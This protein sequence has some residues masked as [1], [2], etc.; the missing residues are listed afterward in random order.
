MRRLP[1]LLLLLSAAPAQAADPKV[2]PAEQAEEA[3]WLQALGVK[4]P[5]PAWP[6]ADPFALPFTR[7][8]LV[9]PTAWY[10][11]RPPQTLRADLFREDVKLL[12]KIMETAY[13]GWDSAKRRGWN[14]DAYFRD[15]DAS[16]AA[17]G[18]QELTLPDAFAPWRKLMEFQLDNHSGPVIAY[19]A[20]S[21]HAI[22]RVSTLDRQPAAACTE[23]RNSQ[24]ATI[25]IT[26]GDPAQQPKRREDID[27]RP[28]SYVVTTSA[29]GPITSIHCG[30]EW[31]A[32]HPAWM[33][34]RDE[35]S[36]NIR[37]LAKTDK[38]V[39]VFRSINGAIGYIRFPSFA[40][41]AV[42]LTYKLE[43]TLKGRPHPEQLLIVDLRSNDGGG[44]RIQALRQWAVLHSSNAHR[45]IAASC[46]YPPLRFGL[47]QS[48]A[49]RLTPPASGFRVGEL[50]RG[51]DALVGSDPAGCPA[52]FV[53]TPATWN[54][55][56]H[57]YPSKPEGRTRLVGLVDDYCASDC[58]LAVD[59]ISAIPG[60]VIAGVNSVGVAQFVQPGYFI[61]PN[62]RLMFR[63]ALGTSDNYGDG[64]SF[65]G[66]GF[67][68]DVLLTSQADI[69]PEG[70]LRL[71]K[72]ILAAR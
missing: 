50:Q 14:W 53:D 6:L 46:L 41:D 64:R 39:P 68:V 27:G 51:L 33:P 13:G 3:R 26:A 17:L 59:A 2:T 52:R 1:F 43:Q 34:S 16:L 31:L 35:A 69:S 22:S 42:D 23:F 11:D 15:W 60:S 62:T 48:G 45:R 19:L 44:M 30:A 61:L 9:P 8:S 12:R 4:L 49:A 47:I 7:R 38:D 72:R 25:P 29:K 5:A 32:A 28:I 67:D 70:V 18:T 36:A 66:Y 65:D 58:E 57:R 56:Q 55:T 20:D 40:P 21:G 63:I 37:A 10:R 24:G 71:A 54:F